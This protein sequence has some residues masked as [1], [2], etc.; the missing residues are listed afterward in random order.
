MCGWLAAVCF[1][2][3]ES[4]F[5]HF[6]A[7]P[8]LLCSF[9]HIAVP[10]FSR[11]FF[12]SSFTHILIPLFSC[13]HTRFLNLFPTYMHA[14]ACICTVRTINSVAMRLYD[15]IFYLFPQSHHILVSIGSAHIFT[16]CLGLY[17]HRIDFI[18][19]SVCRALVRFDKSQFLLCALWF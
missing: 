7:F 13:I 16:F 18:C 11:F 4:L 10:L 19:T 14:A 2:G 17:F 12:V 9:T 1:F 8:F 3:F 5:L 15:T 6:Q